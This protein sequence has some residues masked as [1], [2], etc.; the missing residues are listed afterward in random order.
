[1]LDDFDISKQNLKVLQ[2]ILHF[3][4]KEITDISS[5]LNI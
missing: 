2:I 3:M 4:A 1:M 5:H